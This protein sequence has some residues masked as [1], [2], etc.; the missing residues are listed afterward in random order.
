[1][2]RGGLESGLRM[3]VLQ[4]EHAQEWQLVDRLESYRVLSSP[5]SVASSEVESMRFR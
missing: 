5:S 1:M 3:R 2:S 4:P